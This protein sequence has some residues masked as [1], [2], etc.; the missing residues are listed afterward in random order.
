MDRGENFL[1]G[2]V[3]EP[4]DDDIPILG[5]VSKFDGKKGSGCNG[6]PRW[7]V[8]IKIYCFCII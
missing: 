1:S 2:H 4:V 8:N 5:Y 6:I 3:Y 7:K